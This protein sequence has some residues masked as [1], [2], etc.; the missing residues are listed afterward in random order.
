MK[1]LA[2]CALRL[3][4]FYRF[5]WIFKVLSIAQNRLQDAVSVGRA[6]EELS[7]LKSLDLSGNQFKILPE[8][9]FVHLRSLQMLNLAGNGIESV[10][11]RSFTHLPALRRVD[12]TQNQLRNFPKL[13]F[14]SSPLLEE[15][16]SVSQQPHNIHVP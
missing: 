1:A 6:C 16:R 5:V 15:I 10:S 12:L 13:L 9:S 14:D 8:G 3:N 4:S 2:T 11:P 7:A